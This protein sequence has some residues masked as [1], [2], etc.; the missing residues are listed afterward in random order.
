MVPREYDFQ[1]EGIDTVVVVDDVVVELPHATRARAAEVSA[2]L[3]GIL[4][5]AKC[6]AW[7]STDSTLTEQQA[8]GAPHRRLRSAGFQGDPVGCSHSR[9]PHPTDA[10]IRSA[11]SASLSAPSPLGELVEGVED[12]DGGPLPAPVV[13]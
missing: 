10:K 1:P 7:S 4:R 12:L 2:M 11:G 8:P 3:R 6:I 13:P 9:A 5:L